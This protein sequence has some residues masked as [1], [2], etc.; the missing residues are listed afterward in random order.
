MVKAEGGVYIG[1]NWGNSVCPG[2]ETCPRWR[3]DTTDIIIIRV[4]GLCRCAKSKREVLQQTM[5]VGET[6]EVLYQ[7]NTQWLFLF[8]YFSLRSSLVFPLNQMSSSLFEG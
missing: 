7:Q 4:G 5:Q 3:E 1:V 8:R 6:L 2:L